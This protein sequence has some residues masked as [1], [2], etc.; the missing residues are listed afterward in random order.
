MAVKMVAEKFGLTT[1]VILLTVGP[2]CHF[3][4]RKLMA[5]ISIILTNKSVIKVPK[6]CSLAGQLKTNFNEI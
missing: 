6:N 2:I 1:I 4:D 3:L 5:N